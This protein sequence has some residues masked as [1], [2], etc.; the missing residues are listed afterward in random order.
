MNQL[1]VFAK[2]WQPGQVKTRLAAT[3]G[4]ATAARIYQHGLQLTLRRFSAL[5]DRRSVVVWPPGHD[6]EW[7][8]LLGASWALE[9]QTPGDLGER[10]RQFFQQ[11]FERGSQRVVL[12]GSDSPTLP[13]D[14]IH[15]ALA[16]LES[17]DVVLGPSDDGGYYLIGMKQPLIELF[18]NI[19]WSSPQV[20][21]QT[22]DAAR[23]YHRRLASLPAWYDVD[24]VDQ[25][26]RLQQELAAWPTD[27]TANALSRLTAK[28]MFRP[29]TRRQ[30]DD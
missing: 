23:R 26:P 29:A 24:T 4:G 18:E 30:V 9:F 27:A 25:L 17:H 8:S 13:V 6:T 15:Q 5:A 14:H 3:V 21:Q 28:A 2:Y 19:S 22:L 10:M 12:I 1:S 20:W 7:K 11:A 16:A